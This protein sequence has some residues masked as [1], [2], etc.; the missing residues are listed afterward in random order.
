MLAG[1]VL[2]LE[3]TPP[4]IIFLLNFLVTE[5]LVFE[6]EFLSPG[7]D[8]GLSDDLLTAGAFKGL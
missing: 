8:F 1:G 7:S 4:G 6:L 5:L 2:A 3:Y